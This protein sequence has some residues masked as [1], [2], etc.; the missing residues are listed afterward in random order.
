MATGKF[1]RRPNIVLEVTM[2]TR[3]TSIPNNDSWNAGELWLV[4][5]SSYSYWGDVSWTVS[6]DGQ[7]RSGS[8][9]YDIGPNG[10]QRLWADGFAVRH[11][12]DGSKH[13]G[14]SASASGSDLGSASAGDAYWA[15]QIPRV[16]SITILPSMHDVRPDQVTTLVMNRASDTFQHDIYMDW[17]GQRVGLRGGVA[18]RW[19]WTP[20]WSMLE[21]IPNDT[22]AVSTLTAF[23]LDANRNQIG[24]TQH[25]FRLNVPASVVPTVG[26]I[27]VQD[28]NPDVVA[29]V[30]AFVQGESLLRATIDGQGVYGSTIRARQFTVDGVT[31]ASGGTVPLP[32]SGDRAVGAAVTDSRGRVGTKTALVKVLPYAPP[33]VDG[34]IR[35]ATS[36]GTPDEDAGAYLRIDLAAAAQSLKPATVEKNGLTIRVWSRERGAQTWTERNVITPT[37]LTYNSFFLIS[38]GAVFDITKAY[39][40]RVTV[41]DKLRTVTW[42]KTVATAD[43]LMDWT[44]D[45]VGVKKYRNRGALDVGGDGYFDGDLFSGVGGTVVAPIGSTQI[46]PGKVLPGPGWAWAD[47]A[48]ISRAQYPALFA[49]IGTDY[50]AGNGSTTFNLPNSNGRVVVG[51]DAAQT[52]FNTVGKTGGAKTVTLT[53]AQMPAHSHGQVVTANSGGNGIRQDYYGDRSGLASYPQGADTMSAGGGQ[54]HENMP[55]Y[56]V[57]RYIIRIA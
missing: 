9:R 37:G 57:Q 26:T 8:S 3:S 29:A 30:G 1:S 40:V 17:A 21:A 11:N 2:G 33:Q 24:S 44:R 19:D 45:G 49:L 41:T 4:N 23:T 5:T 53:Q 6:V 31:A 50:G 15:P 28:A 18:D 34:T 43:I 42:E 51:F 38:G 16:S 13:V 25:N 27:T 20:A 39:D 35:R 10:R 52:E 46:W 22:T 7:E 36:T 56:V 54:A 14:Y 48:A 47:G 32:A 55:P 12:D